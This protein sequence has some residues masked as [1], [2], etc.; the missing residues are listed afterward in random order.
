MK[1]PANA[2][3]QMI[4]EMLPKGHET[5]SKRPWNSASR[6]YFKQSFV[7]SYCKGYFT[8]ISS[9]FEWYCEVVIYVNHCS[10]VF[11]AVITILPER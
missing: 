8:I 10:A 9:G 3:D 4:F 11:P 7:M 2:S 1:S 5:Q 6:V